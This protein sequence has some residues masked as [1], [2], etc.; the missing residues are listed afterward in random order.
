MR[1]HG[2]DSS[3]SGYVQVVGSCADINETSGPIKCREFRLAEDLLASY[4][5]CAVW[6]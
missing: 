5:N 6:I 1:G 4:K 2:L 3:G